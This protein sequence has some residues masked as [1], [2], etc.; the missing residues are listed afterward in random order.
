MPL[1]EYTKGI[2]TELRRAISGFDNDIRLGIF[3]ALKKNG[4]LS[5]SELSE[6][7]DMK[8]DKAKLDFHLAKLTESAL[9][10]HRYR[11]QLGNERFSFYSTTKFGENLWNNVASSLRPPSP[12]MRMEDS[13]GKDSQNHLFSLR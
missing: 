1:E 3:L 4:E 7:L 11:H 12:I 2:P 5:F 13:S 6:K 8:T 10:E 9:V